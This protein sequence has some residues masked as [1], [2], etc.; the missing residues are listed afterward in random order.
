MPVTRQRLR[1]RGYNQ[2]MEIAR[3]ISETANLPILNKA[4]KRIHFDT[5]QTKMKGWERLENVENV[6]QLITPETVK[7]KHLL[8]VDDIVTTGAT[9]RACA[10]ELCKAGNVQISVLSIGFTKE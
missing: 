1:Q 9:V 5:S 4:I 10:Q 7:D 3:G 8:L 6:F 2:S